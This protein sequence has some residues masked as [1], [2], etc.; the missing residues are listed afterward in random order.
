ME[1]DQFLIMTKSDVREL[2]EE[3]LNSIAPQEEQEWVP[4]PIAMNTL[5]IKSKSH[6]WKLRSE[7]LIEYSKM[8]PKVIL[9]RMSSLKTFI[10]S[11]AQKTF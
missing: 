4:E 8:S 5:G 2:L 11:H 9:Y 6:L 3:L 1:K 7:G 10:Q